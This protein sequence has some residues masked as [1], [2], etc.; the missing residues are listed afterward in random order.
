MDYFYRET[1]VKKPRKQY[2]CSF[3]GELIL[4]EH[5]YVAA[6]YGDFYTYRAH[7]DCHSLLRWIIA[8]DGEVDDIFVA[9][10]EE[11]QNTDCGVECECGELLPIP[12]ILAHRT[13]AHPDINPNL[14]ASCFDYELHPEKYAKR[15]NL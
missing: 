15:D 5:I 13:K 6:S 11:T 3:C 2:R 1:T 9:F 12:M 7:E 14:C 10:H 4:G 8:E